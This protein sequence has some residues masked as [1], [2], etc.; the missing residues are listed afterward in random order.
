MSLK[1]LKTEARRSCAGRGHLMPPFRQ[2][3]YWK[4]KFYSNCRQCDAQ[5]IVNLNPAP[6]E[7][8]ICGEAVAIGCDSGS[9][10][11]SRK[12]PRATP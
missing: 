12:A 9:T 6:N 5:V 7:I 3:D 4:D 11:D 8:D 2:D 1:T 10:Y